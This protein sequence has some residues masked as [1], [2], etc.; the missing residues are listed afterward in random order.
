[1]NTIPVWRKRLRDNSGFSSQDLDGS[2]MEAIYADKG[3][4]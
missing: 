3:Y 4:Y 2:D 1:M